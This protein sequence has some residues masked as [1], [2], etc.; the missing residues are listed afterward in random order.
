MGSR[1]HWLTKLAKGANRS[2]WVW[3]V[4]RL[5]GVGKP[6]KNGMAGSGP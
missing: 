4:A 6:G 2:R 1:Y 3:G 5:E